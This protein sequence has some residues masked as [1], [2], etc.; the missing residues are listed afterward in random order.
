ML[1]QLAGDRLVGGAHDGVRL[2]SRQPPGR[3]VDQRRR[4]LD[5]A[6]GVID[7]LRH[8]VVAD[9]EMHQAALRLRAPV[10]VGRH[11]DAAHRIGLVTLAGGVDADRDVVQDGMR[12]VVHGIVSFHGSEGGGDRE[13]AADRDDRE[14]VLAAVVRP[15]AHR[16]RSAARGPGGLPRP[17]GPPGQYCGL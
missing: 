16:R 8:A 3:G 2:P 11:V 6:V 10:A 9:R 7:A 1:V 13:A 17:P 5:V 14:Q 15:P 12:L 4:L